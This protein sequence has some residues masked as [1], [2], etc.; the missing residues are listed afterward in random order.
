[1]IP[2]E[3]VRLVI[4]DKV[5][6][7]IGAGFS[8]S[9]GY[10]GWMDLLE[11]LKNVIGIIDLEFGDMRN[12]DP[13]QIAQSFL[14]YYKEVNWE[15]CEK[16]VIEGLGLGE[17][18]DKKDFL[19]GP[20]KKIVQEE[21]DNKLELDFTKELLGLIKVD[22]TKVNTEDVEKLK[23]L[24]E[25]DFS[26]FLTTNYDRVIEEEIMKG[27][28]YLVQS[29]GKGEELNW[30]EKDKTIIKIHGDIDSEKGI[31]FTHSQY[32]KFMHDFGYFKS[33]LYNLFS[34]NVILMMG[35]GFNDINIHQTYFQFIRDYGTQVDNNKFYMV[36]SSYDKEKW[37]TYFS[38]YK[39]FLESYKINVIEAE[40]LPSFV[41][42]LSNAIRNEKESADL[43]LLFDTLSDEPRFAETLVKVINGEEPDL[44]NNKSLNLDF[45]RAFIK[46]FTS[47]FILNEEPFKKELVDLN[48]KIG[49]SIM[50]YTIK[51]LGINPEIAS[52]DT[53]LE[54][55]KKSLK[56]VDET[57]D[58]HGK[59]YRAER[60]IGLSKH[61]NRDDYEIE[62]G[63]LMYQMF[64]S[65]HPTQYLYSNPG[66]RFLLEH[67]H[68]IP[69]YYL[70]SYLYFIIHDVEE[71]EYYL[72]IN[73]IQKYWIE[74]IR[75]KAAGKPSVLEVIEK[76]D[77]IRKKRKEMEEEI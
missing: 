76:I 23:K 55:V 19:N 60:F 75:E 52:E 34:S 71:D 68:Q 43:S 4:L 44:I 7:F 50:D 27:K 16:D 48:S 29:L 58:F 9:F 46:I 56:Y 22:E 53:Y 40:N 66:G 1:M 59:R 10:P 11:E 64:G 61:I 25:I 38:Y 2:K 77:E 26:Y 21:T 13:L 12:G 67:L 57:T 35:Y 5:V 15:T 74:R 3:L 47:P 30:N 69:S 8:R 54:F 45:I 24:S 51:I 41:E 18:Y 72:P 37:G 70:L 32:Y 62:T 36:L 39:R 63:K 28:N 49:Y 20:L 42:E 73:H 6:P 65:C 14:S 17:N 31:I 33:K